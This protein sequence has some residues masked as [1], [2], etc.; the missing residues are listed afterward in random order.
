MS[1]AMAR[2]PISAEARGRV[3]ALAAELQIPAAR[4]A[5]G[6][7]RLPAKTLNPWE[8]K[9]RVGAERAVAKMAGT[10]QLAFWYA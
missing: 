10:N 3:R 6:L 4:M 5:A 9:G 8:W 1:R 2:P 7:A